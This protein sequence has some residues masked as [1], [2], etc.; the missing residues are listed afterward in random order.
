MESTELFNQFSKLE[1]NDVKTVELVK[2][3][4]N[5]TGWS[6]HMSYMVACLIKI[7]NKR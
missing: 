1:L 6:V 7:A 5:R 4:K 2:W 3:L